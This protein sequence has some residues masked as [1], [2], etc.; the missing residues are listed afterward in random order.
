MKDGKRHACAR[1]PVKYGMQN[2]LQEPECPRCIL[3]VFL[4][5]FR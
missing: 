1:V 5:K 4:L 3:H 2:A